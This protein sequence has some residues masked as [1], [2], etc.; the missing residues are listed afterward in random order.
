[1]QPLDSKLAC[2]NKQ[3]VCLLACLQTS[4]IGGAETVMARH[5]QA[6]GV[7]G[8][9]APAACRRPKRAT[10]SKDAPEDYQRTLLKQRMARS[11]TQQSVPS[12]QQ[13]ISSEDQHPLASSLA[14]LQELEDN[15][16]RRRSPNTSQHQLAG[17][18][19]GSQN[20]LSHSN[21]VTNEL[22]G[23]HMHTEDREMTAAESK[24]A[25]T[26]Q[27]YAA[28]GGVISSTGKLVYSTPPE[29]DLRRALWNQ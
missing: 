18:K 1:M 15:E 11:V 7:V 16:L 24:Q 8:D 2:A 5:E 25:L 23:R 28:T 4:A 10:I 22:P 27:H 26:S 17:A 13:P 9:G 19:A 6:V 14:R 21:P 20:R 3:K 29:F 12:Q